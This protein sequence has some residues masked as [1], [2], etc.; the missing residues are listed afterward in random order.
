M[1][2]CT[3]VWI[4]YLLALP[5]QPAFPQ[6]DASQL[7]K[8][9]GG[10]VTRNLFGNY[11]VPTVGGYE[12]KPDALEQRARDGQLQLTDEDAVRLALENSVDVNVERYTPY[13]TLWGVQRGRAILNTV[14]QFN[15]NIN[16]L[17]TPASS[18][19]QGGDTV[20]NLNNLYDVTVHKPFEPGLDVD[21]KFNTSRLRTNS[22]FTSLNPSLAPQLSLTFT[23][24][25]LKDF[26]RISRGRSVRIARNSYGMSQEGFVTKVSDIVTTVLN[27]Y[28]D[29]V[30][31]DE[32][33]KVKEASRKLAEVVLEQ[34]KIQ[35][36]VG[37]MAPL[38][39]IQAEAEVAARVEQ[40]VVS[41]FNRRIAEEQLKKLIS[42][43]EDAGAITV[44]LTPVST[45][46][47]DL[48]PAGDP[49]QAI[50]RALEVR[51]EVKQLELDQQNK[52]IQVEYARNQL[53]PSLDFVAGY[54]QNGLGGNRIIRDYSQG[55]FGAPIVDF[56]PGGFYDSLDS[57]FSRKYL[58]YTLGFNF[59]VPI[60][61]DE[62]RANSAQ[63]QI[64]YRQGEEKIRALRQRIALEVRQAEDNVE[65]NLARI[66]TSAVTVR[67][68]E[69]RLQGEQDKYALGATTTRFI[70]EAQRDLQDAQSRLLKA[71][72]DLIKSRIALDR[73]VGD[74]FSA[75]NIDLEQQLKSNFQ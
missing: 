24:H 69:R 63:A 54:S 75:H 16:R 71:K 29:L 55:I 15:T 42:S 23:Q 17:V 32:D 7:D 70:L 25:L 56:Q 13:F 65:L 5:L 50:Q 1:R 37:T 19:L 51:P 38:D 66:Q 33:I 2:A 4:F 57:L 48:T 67:Y 45:P 59:R 21:F 28:W 61:N 31:T 6:T 40:V 47:P 72:I 44:A 43:R 12:Q 35:A 30:Y 74:T 58:G 22:F 53:R 73:A 60:G 46:N 39:V 64:D 49:R 3:L 36:E 52:Q 41:K 62:A 27:T 11:T 20:L 26:G 10:T 9:K 34:N 18:A 14:V 68:Q 8:V